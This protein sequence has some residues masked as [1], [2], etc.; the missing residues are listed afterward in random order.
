MPRPRRTK[1]VAP[2]PP[3]PDDEPPK[4]AAPSREA[5]MGMSVRELKAALVERGLSP[6]GMLEKGDFVEALLGAMN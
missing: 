4:P 2:S 3:P 6:D 1:P 5:L